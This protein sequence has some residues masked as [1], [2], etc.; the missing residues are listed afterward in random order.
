LAVNRGAKWS[1]AT[2]QSV[3]ASQ[4]LFLVEYA[5]FNT[6]TAIGRGVCDK[7]DDAATNMSNVTGATAALGNSSGAAVG[8]NGLVSITYRGEENFWGNIWKWVDGLNIQASS[9]HYAWIADKNFADDTTTGYAN[10]GFTL[11]KA[12]GYVSAFGHSAGFDWL[13]LPSAVAGSDANPVGDYFYQNNAYSGFLVALL[14]GAW[15]S[16]SATGGC[17]WY[18]H[19]ASSYR[20]RNVGARSL[21]VP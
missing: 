7:T 1:L 21:H 14:G 13:F 6:Q 4:L 15:I 11:A 3:S 20:Y 2:I 10:A 8:T 17:Y 18:L 12:N 19:S 9:L 16:S 5:S